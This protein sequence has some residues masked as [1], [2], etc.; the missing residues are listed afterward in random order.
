MT[1]E[2]TWQGTQTVQATCLNHGKLRVFNV[3]ETMPVE[4]NCTQNDQS[5]FSFVTETK[6]QYIMR[7][8]YGT[9]HVSH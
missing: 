9:K 4:C 5:G 1:Y 3:G 2:I 7:K 6:Q 8:A